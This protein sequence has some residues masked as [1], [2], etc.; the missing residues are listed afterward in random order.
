MVH[1]TPSRLLHGEAI[2]KLPMMAL[3]QLNGEFKT[4]RI[5]YKALFERYFV[6]PP[7]HT[8]KDAIIIGLDIYSSVRGA[9]VTFKVKNIDII[10]Y[11]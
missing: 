8:L 6:P 2:M 11:Q 10:G 5:D 9:D 4:V 1:S 3:P 7:G